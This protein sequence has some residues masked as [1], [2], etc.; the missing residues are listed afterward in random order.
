MAYSDVCK[1]ADAFSAKMRIH[2]KKC[3]AC[4]KGNPCG[5]FTRFYNKAKK[6]AEKAWEITIHG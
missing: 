3:R 4:K 5:V 2:S 1:V 6:D